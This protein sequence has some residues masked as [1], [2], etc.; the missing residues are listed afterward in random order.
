[1]DVELLGEAKDESRRGAGNFPVKDRLVR[2][3]G[4]HARIALPGAKLWRALRRRNSTAASARGKAENVSWLMEAETSGIRQITWS[5]RG[6]FV[7]GKE[8]LLRGGY[9]HHDNGMGSASYAERARAPGKDAEGRRLQRH[10]LRHNPA[11]CGAT[12][13]RRRPGHVCDG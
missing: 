3:S 9:M 1:M 13:S 7:N 11:S 8:T 4:F 5:P 2:E 6:L 10:P 12:Q